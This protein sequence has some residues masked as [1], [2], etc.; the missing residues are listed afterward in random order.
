M[1]VEELVTCRVLRGAEAPLRL[2]EERQIKVKGSGRG[3]RSTLCFH[4][5]ETVRRFRV[6]P[7]HPIGEGTV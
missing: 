4:W 1:G 5:H 7:G 3:A 2:W 6:L